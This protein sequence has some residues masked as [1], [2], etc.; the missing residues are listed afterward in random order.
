MNNA[1]QRIAVVIPCY[2]VKAQILGVLAKIGHEVSHIYV[3]DD[4]CPEKS[5]DVVES[6]CQDSRVRVLRH[7]VNQGVGGAVSAGYAAALADDAD[8][9]VK[10]DGDGQMDPGLIAGLVHPIFSG[11]ADYSKGNRFYH[12]SDVTGMP[13]LRLFGNAVLSFLTKLSSG[14]WQS[15]D[16]T[17][18]FTAIHGVALKRIPLDRLARRYFFESDMLFHLNQARAVVCDFPMSA[19]YADESSSLRPTR[20]LLPFLG[21]HLRNFTRR[22]VYSYFIRGFSLASLELVLGSALMLFGV[23]FGSISWAESL[24]TAQTASAGTVMLSALPIILGMQ[25]LLSWLNFDVAAEPR[26][27]LSRLFGRD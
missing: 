8:V 14:Y 13:R 5:G 2:R 12:L 23:V 26:I 7:S 11:E 4:A 16:P 27:A 17:N 9:V 18:G 25:L 6:H 3:V 22:I 19:C 24:R 21:G 20:V 1:T 10:L 15:F